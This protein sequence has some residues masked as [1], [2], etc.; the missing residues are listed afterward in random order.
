MRSRTR[1]I[2]RMA[3]DTP[4]S[5]E[6][7]VTFN[8][9]NTVRVKVTP[10]GRMELLRQHDEFR[11]SFPGLGAWDLRVDDEGYSEFQLWDLMQ[12]LGHLCGLGQQVPFETDIQ[13]ARKDLR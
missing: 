7:R 12:Q 1:G 8:V 9:N 3:T 5:T 10:V 13:I 6:E 11:K 4:L 2:Y